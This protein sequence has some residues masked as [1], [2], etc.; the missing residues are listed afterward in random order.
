MVKTLREAFLS[1]QTYPWLSNAWSNGTITDMYSPT[2]L[3]GLSQSV[4]V[5]ETF[6]IAAPIIDPTSQ[7]MKE[8]LQDKDNIITRGAHVKNVKKPIRDKRCALLTT[9]RLFDLACYFTTM[10]RSSVVY[11]RQCMPKIIAGYGH[12]MYQKRIQDWVKV[13]YEWKGN[14]LALATYTNPQLVPGTLPPQSGYV[15]HV[16][17]FKVLY[18]TIENAICVLNFHVAIIHLS[19]LREEN[20]NGALPDWDHSFSLKT[21]MRVDDKATLDNDPSIIKAH[22]FR[23]PLHL[24]ILV[25]PIF[26]L[27]QFRI[28]KYTWERDSLLEYSLKL[29]NNKP[30][31]LLRVER[32]IWT[33]FFSVLN[34]EMALHDAMNSLVKKIPWVELENASPEI[35]AWFDLSCLSP[36]TRSKA[37]DITE[38]LDTHLLHDIERGYGAQPGHHL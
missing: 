34:H 29:G 1:L 26:L 9:L 19:Y 13:L 33:T 23:L 4:Q 16:N 17:A 10:Q 24:A 12:K 8:L 22:R 21:F 35:R 27:S 28:Y 5:Y 37:V 2:E 32:I 15:S 7:A 6:L 11:E 36:D 30:D 20:F 38:Q 18:Q 3:S 31:I 25:S 14:M